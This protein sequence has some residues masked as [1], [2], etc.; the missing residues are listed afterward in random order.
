MCNLWRI[1]TAAYN[2]INYY[3]AEINAA[4]WLVD[5]RSGKSHLSRSSN[6]S[7]PLKKFILP[8]RENI[9]Q[10]KFLRKLKFILCRVV[11]TKNTPRVSFTISWRNKL[12]KCYVSRRTD[13]AEQNNNKNSCE[14][15]F[16]GL[17]YKIRTVKPYNKS[18]INLVCSVCTGK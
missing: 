16:F 17:F 15:V 3:M 11:T 10:I 18:L 9:V 2:N 7:F 6:S 5:Y 14:K 4:G 12:P 8:A 13:N 1:S